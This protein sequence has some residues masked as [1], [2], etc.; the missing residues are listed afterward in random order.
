M[1]R[2][3]KFTATVGLRYTM[4]VARGRLALSS[5]LYYTSKFYFDPAG[6]LPQNH[7]ATLGLRAEW[8]DP[9]GKYS[10][11]VYGDNVTNT[12]YLTQLYANSPGAPETWGAPATVAGEL[13]ARF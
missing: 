5:N 13:R 7:Y 3:P 9:S 12:K 8:T 4:D 6:Q 1:L 10:V 11:A 2:A